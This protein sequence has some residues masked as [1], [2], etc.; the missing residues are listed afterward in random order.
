M[1]YIGEKIEDLQMENN[2]EFRLKKEVT[3]IGTG[4]R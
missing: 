4:Y 1:V 2:D 3:I